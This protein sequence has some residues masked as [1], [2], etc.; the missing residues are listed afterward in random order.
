MPEPNTLMNL[1]DLAKPAT[2][3]IEQVCAAIGCVFEP[4]QIR[5]VAEAR[6]DADKIAAMS[7]IEITEIQYRAVQRMVIEEAQKQQNIEAITYMAL[8]MLD[9]D[10]DPSTMESDW[11]SNF[12]DKCRLISDS[13]MQQL[14]SRVLAG[15]A[16]Q[17]G[18]F[19]KR[20]VNY[21]GSLDKYDA[22]LFTSLCRFDPNGDGVPFI[23]DSYAEVYEQ[24]GINFE[25]LSHLAS[26]GLISFGPSAFCSADHPNRFSVDVYGKRY[27][28]YAKGKKLVR[29]FSIGYVMFTQVGR[30]LAGLCYPDPVEGFDE[31]LVAQWKELG[32]SVTEE[33]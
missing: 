5:R 8:P 4:W 31:Y 25:T 3:L 16:N 1:G 20:T 28:L 2:V 18:S 14:W 19:S 6:A 23:Y 12:F 30:E 32:Y 27:D 15:E 26:I 13:E 24:E 10:A 21:L 11:I 17:P 33:R 7:E 29:D 9:D 22:T